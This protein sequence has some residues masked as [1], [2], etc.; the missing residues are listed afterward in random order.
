LGPPF[1]SRT[2]LFEM[3]ATQSL[4]VSV[5][6]FLCCCLDRNPQGDGPRP[7]DL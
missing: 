4:R 5:S 7:G 3:R 1:R 2:P 6:L